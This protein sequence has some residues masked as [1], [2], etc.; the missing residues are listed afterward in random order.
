MFGVI[1]EKL[2]EIHLIAGTPLESKASYRRL[3]HEIKEKIGLARQ[4]TNVL[5]DRREEDVGILWGVDNAVSSLENFLTTSRWKAVKSELVIVLEK[6][7][8]EMN[9]VFE[10]D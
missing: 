10:Q 7:I 2:N 3:L 4:R 9:Q 1:R 6:V 8:Q 5:S